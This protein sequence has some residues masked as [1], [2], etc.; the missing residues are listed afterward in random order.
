MKTLR[1]LGAAAAFAS[2]AL[3]AGCSASGSASSLPD[4][5]PASGAA[6][7]APADYA[8]KGGGAP[9]G[10]P[11]GVPGTTVEQKLARTARVSITVADVEAAAAQVRAVAASVDGRV[12]NENLVVRGEADARPGPTSTLVISVPADR[13]DGALDQLKSIGIVKSRVVS[14][15]DVTLQVADVDARIRTLNDSIARLRELWKRAGSVSELTTLEN[16]IS[17]RIAE[18]DSMVAQQ[19]VLARRVAQ[20]P[21]TITLATP[22]QASELETTGFLG[23]LMAGWNALVVSSRML[24]TAI[25]ALLPFA[26]AAAV[27]AVPLV[28]WRR[29]LRRRASVA[30]EDPKT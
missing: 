26:V 10:K 15:E 22:E 1:A 18:R 24:M 17:A 2:L 23:G 5:V 30:E 20:S 7:P 14:S 28:A 21:I 12:T 27:V 13:L 9:E 11:E 25:G 29:R 16:E 3:L 8:D 4:G 19:E 6:E